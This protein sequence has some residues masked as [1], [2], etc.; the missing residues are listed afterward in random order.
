MRPLRAALQ[1][2]CRTDRSGLATLDDD[3]RDSM[4]MLALPA[5]RQLERTI[6]DARGIAEEGAR[7]A[8]QALA[9]QHREPHPH[10]GEPQRSLR[11]R[12]RAHARQLGDRHEAESGTQTIDHLA[13][14]CA[15]EHWHGMLF[16]RFLAENDLLIEPEMRVAVTLDECEE[17][18]KDHNGTCKSGD[19]GMDKWTLAARFAHAMLP[20]VF[21]PDLP[22][23][24]V[25]LAQEH[26]QKLEA[27][28]EGLPAEVFTA[29]DALGWV[30]QFW[31]SQKKAEVNAAETKI[32]AD[33]LPAVT[34]LFTEPYMV[35]FLLA[36]SLGAWWADRFPHKP[37]PPPIAH[38]HVPS[39]SSR[40]EA[41]PDDLA[42]LKVLDP[43]CGS[44][45]F[46]VAAFLSLVPMRM[47]A[48]NLSAADA[49]DAVLRDN[50]HGLE[51]DRRCVAIAA[52]ALALEAWRYP[53]A[54]GF[55]P[56]PRLRLAWCGQP[57]A[58]ERELWV[59]LAGGDP[60]REAGMAALHRAFAQAP[61][62]GSLVDPSESRGDLLTADFA[63]LRQLLDNALHASAGDEQ[64]DELAVAAQ[65]L[66]E[67]AELLTQRYHLIFTNVPY[68]G[69][70]KQTGILRDFCETHYPL[71]KHDLATVFIQRLLNLC[72]RGGELLLVL[73]RNWLFLV[74]YKALRKRLLTDRRWLFL[75]TLGPGAF[76]T[77]TGEVVNTCFLALGNTPRSDD[78]SFA[79]LDV[80]Q[81]ATSKEKAAALEQ[82]PVTTLSQAGQIDNPDCVI[83]YVAEPSLALLERKASSYQGLATSDNAQFVFCFWEVLPG[84]DGWEFFQFAPANTCRMTGCSH[85]IFWQDGGGKYADHATALKREGRLGGWKSG[86]A[87]WGKRGVAVN[88]MGDLPASLYFGTKFDCNVAVLIPDDEQDIAPLWAYCS[89]PQY[90]QAVR[91][92]NKK[93]SVTNGT[94]AK[95]PYDAEHWKRVANSDAEGL[96]DIDTT[97][98]TQWGFHGH[99][100]AASAPLQVAMARLLGYRWPAE[101]A[102]GLGLSPASL[103]WIEALA[104]CEPYADEDGIVC[105]PSVS[106]ERAAHDRLFDLL[107]AC[108]GDAWNDDMYER[109]LAEACTASLGDWLRSRFFEEHCKLFHQ[110]PFIW[111]IWDGR[112]DGF[113]AFVSYHKLAAGA[114]AG[115]RLLEK[116]TYGYLGDWLSRQQDACNRGEVGA[117]E[118]MAAALTL[119]NTLAAILE[120]ETPFD[121]FVR[122]K[123]LAEQAAGWAPDVNDGVR[124]NIRPFMAQDIPGG[125]RGAGILRM[126]PNIHWKKDKGK[127]PRR[128]REHFPWF[129]A[130]DGFTGWRVNDVHLPLAE[131]HRARR[132]RQ[133]VPAA[134]KYDAER[135]VA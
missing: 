90:N 1:H 104:H 95:V 22:V 29:A 21:R 88:R 9:V 19:D 131:K 61:V 97:D 71:A 23:F 64:L 125:R 113:H 2:D 3:S 79:W 49:I 52:F 76:E 121:I 59:A 62:L 24:E 133:A 34:Q 25:R 50:L 126:K 111:H 110:R 82:A 92:L 47:A 57:M 135:G 13:Q 38:A 66:A 123:S 118:R 87:A 4:T 44:G 96:L 6:A 43:C 28:V 91:A 106:G 48:E 93:V 75:A 10:M 129:W 99:P 85:V 115:R 26:R 102:A 108:W 46:L 58:S 39:P 27:L 5:R 119:Q 35:R 101:S 86:H 33:E 37:C 14:E 132:V 130:D 83:G 12:L 40:F 124:L 105:L 128:N 54:G 36:N 8:L 53:G 127:E 116:L 60:R 70:E 120:G 74:R 81:F 42:A 15:Y 20:Q 55:R 63:D 112:P 80:S 114:G 67:A 98:P 30:Y 122:W 69:R 11:R 56:L 89:A 7:A 73:P 94:L 16:A 77:I 109:L 134:P 65:G 103:G 51:L 18:A 72:D 100:C 107:T 17:L 41:W 84:Q 78:D 31:Q 68:L 45:H 117:D 32:G